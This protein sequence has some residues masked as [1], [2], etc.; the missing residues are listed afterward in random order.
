[1]SNI[2]AKTSVSIAAPVSTVW[3]AL[4]TPETIKRYMFGATVISDWKEGSS[5]VWKGEWQG[6]PY[7]DRGQIVRFEPERTLQYTHWSPLSGRP[8]TP[9]NRHIV[10]IELTDE[11]GRTKVLLSQDGNRSDDER[12]H[13]EETWQRML[14]GLKKVSERSPSNAR[15][16]TVFHR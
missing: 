6:K 12:R 10:T 15:D 1:M 3:R 16:Q 5:V 4:V 7:E 11:D 13:S 9:A 2:I 14:E 8:D